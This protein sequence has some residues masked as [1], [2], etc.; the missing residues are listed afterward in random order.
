MS[1]HFSPLENVLE[2]FKSFLDLIFKEISNLLPNQTKYWLPVTM[3]DNP[4]K[5]ENGI[6]ME[7]L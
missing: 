2:N 6:F 3:Q 1:P 7:T 4:K 5:S